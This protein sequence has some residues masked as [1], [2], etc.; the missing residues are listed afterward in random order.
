MTASR[1]TAA[2]LSQTLAKRG[3]RS[4]SQRAV[5]Y[6]VLLKTRDHPTPDEIF[7]RVKTK[8]PGISLAT[9]YNCLDALEAHNLIRAFRFESGS[10]RYCSNL[11]PHAHFRDK[12]TGQTHDIK[13]P[14]EMT[15]Q[16]KKLLPKSYDLDDIEITFHGKVRSTK[17]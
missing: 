10:T 14:H 9:I 8:L 2:D 12:A 13:V 15:A 11:E 16:L 7:A 1:Q 17:H 3:L 4:T 5:V 6:Q